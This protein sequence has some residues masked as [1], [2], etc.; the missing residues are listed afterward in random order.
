V[1]HRNTTGHFL[2]I[3]GPWNWL[4][5]N[6][7]LQEWRVACWQDGRL[8]DEILCPIARSPSSSP[9]ITTVLTC[10]PLLLVLLVDGVDLGE[11]GFTG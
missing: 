4:K 3:F 9:V 7:N 10:L 8:T 11:N 6:S 2:A 1:R 5:L